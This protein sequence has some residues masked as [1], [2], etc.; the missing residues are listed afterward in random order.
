MCV[1]YNVCIYLCVC[2]HITPP[3]WVYM[4]LC[5]SL[6][7]LPSLS[8]LASWPAA[9]CPIARFTQH[10]SS[11]LLLAF[12]KERARASHAPEVVGEVILVGE[13]G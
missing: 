1:S 13:G 10:D 6:C 8:L 2:V 12:I 4:Y 5:V 3:S 9:R 11:T 7:V